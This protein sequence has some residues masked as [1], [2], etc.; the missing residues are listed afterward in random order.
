MNYFDVSKEIVVITGGSG[1]LGAE[2]ARTFLDLNAKVVCLDISDSNDTLNLQKKFPKT[3]LFLEADITSKD[4]IKGALSEI[5][6]TIGPPT[7]LINNA[8]LD[9][10]PSAPPED[11][12][13][14]ENYPESSWDK[15]LEVNLKGIFLACQVIGSE[16]A[17]NKQG[18]IINISSIYG[19]V[20]PDQ[21][22]YEYLR[23]EGTEFYKP[24]SYSASKSGILN[25]TRYLA[26]YWAKHEVRVNTL[27]LAGVFSNQDKRFLDAY[28]KRIPIIC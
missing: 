21:S 7:V 16:M 18:S 17:K 11:T 3:F 12:K 19:L 25:L 8:G 24:I 28:C 13:A 5:I 20:S 22:I 26:A 14:F 4:S 6:D 27:T 9:S 10:P 23:N 2:Y 1:V 15:V